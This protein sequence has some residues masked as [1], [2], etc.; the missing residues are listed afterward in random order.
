MIDLSNTAHV[1]ILIFLSAFWGFINFKTGEDAGATTS[2]ICFVIWLFKLI[3]F[4][5]CIGVLI[6]KNL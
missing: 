5:M 1:L 4:V 2:F 6:T 3:I